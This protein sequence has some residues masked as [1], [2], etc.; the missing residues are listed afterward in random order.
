MRLL[1]PVVNIHA[2]DDPDPPNLTPIQRAMHQ[3]GRI[4]GMMVSV[5]LEVVVNENGRVDSATP[6]GGPEKFYAQAQ[7]IEMHRAFQPVRIDGQI[8]RVEFT[9]YVRVYP[10]ERWESVHIPLPEVPYM[11]T[12]NISLERT[13]CLGSCPSY[14]VTLSGDGDITFVAPDRPYAFVTVPGIHHA[15]VSS[16]TMRELWNSFRRADFL[17]AQN[18]YTCNWTDMPSQTLTVT[19]GKITK[20]VHDYGG[21]VVGLPEAIEHLESAIDEAADT[22]RWVRGNDNTLSSLRA[23]HWNFAAADATNLALYNNAI[24]SKR[25]PLTDAFIVAKTPLVSADKNTPSPICAASASGDIDLVQRMLVTP[26]KASSLPPHVRYECLSM[27]AT[28]G[29]IPVVDFWLDHHAPLRL[30]YP[31]SSDEDDDQGPQSPL[32]AAVSRGHISIVKRLLQRGASVS[33]AANDGHSL[34]AQAVDRNDDEHPGEAASI[35][36]LLLAAGEDPNEED[37]WNRPP[38]FMADSAEI[39]QLLLGAGAKVNQRDSSGGTALMYAFD[40]EIAKLLLESGADPTSRDK[41]GKSALDHAKE[42]GRKDSAALIQSALDAQIGLHH[43]EDPSGSPPE[44][45]ATTTP[46]TSGHP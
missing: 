24:A 11:R 7:E 1:T 29:S 32:F 20:T 5:T 28:S 21:L 26:A 30:A 44:S 27:A 34:L 35:V 15:R 4:F 25:T 16:D 23:E 17:S 39:A 33:L 3:G 9:D 8:R 46:P 38:L 12:V 18:D 40:P 22:A 19:F 6:T 13:G 42:F 10:Q 37:L 45:K 41:D 43:T 2:D 14:K 36:K 31:K